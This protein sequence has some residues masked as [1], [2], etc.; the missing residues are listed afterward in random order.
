MGS[1]ELIAILCSPIAFQPA[2]VVFESPNYTQLLEKVGV[3]QLVSDVIDELLNLARTHDCEFPDDFRQKTIEKMTSVELPST[4]YQDFQSRRPMEVETYLGSPIKLAT[5]SDVRVP[6][7]ETLYAM[8]HHINATNLSKPPN[9]NSP[10]PVGTQ[11]PRMSSA[12]PPHRGPMNGPMR[13]GP[14]RAPSGV[15]MPPP[16]RGMMRPPPPP[17]AHPQPPPASRIPRDTSVEGL[18]EFSHLVLYEN[19]EGPPSQQSQQPQNG[20]N[21]NMPDMPPGPPP[22][23]SAAEL[24]LQ[25]RELALR[26]R[27]LQVKEQEMSKRR[28]RRRPAPSRA[29]FDEED[30]DD[31]F[32]PMENP[33]PAPHIDPDNVD[34]MSLTSRRNRKMPSASQIRKNPEVNTNNSRPSSSFSRYFGGGR[35]RASDRIMQEIPGLHD[36]L[37]DNPM[38]SYSSNRYGA[39]DRNQMQADSRANSM[40]TSR[41]GDFPTYPYPPSRRNS[42]SPAAPFGP[43]GPRM[44]RPMT[45]QEQQSLGPPNGPPHGPNPSPP[46]NVRAP[47][48]RYPTGHG[49]AV[50]PQQVEQHN[51]VSNQ[52]PAKGAP[53]NKSL[54][55]SASASAKSG[56]SGSSANLESENSA[57]SSQI[58]LGAQQP[59]MPVR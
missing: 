32:D 17:G 59:T 50:N 6:R 21:N 47:V 58:S 8:L 55:G 26:Q 35:K 15:M 4:M 37:M 51:G 29:T 54:T 33:I 25:E 31:Y 14:V 24:S 11:G 41:M 45:A 34:M 43:P 56:D 57:H 3:R 53:N 48:P 12:P 28:G 39:V 46:G 18:E 2:S 10:P 38:M 36:S 42:H 27:E 19:G 44:G 23:A 22:A 13:P 30:E 16:R 7:I 5:E 9:R 52:F 20:V 1:L 49:H 40:T